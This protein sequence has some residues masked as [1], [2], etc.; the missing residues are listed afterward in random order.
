VPTVEVRERQNPDLWVTAE[1]TGSGERTRVHRLRL[2]NTTIVALRVF[3]QSPTF[4][5][6]RREAVAQ[7]GQEAVLDALNMAVR[8]GDVF[9]YGVEQV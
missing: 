9:G 2:V 8:A 3:A 5:G 6:G 4:T 1:E 7:P